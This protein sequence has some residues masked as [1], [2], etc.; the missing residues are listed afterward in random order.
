MKKAQKVTEVYNVLTLLQ[1]K[2]HLAGLT[3]RLILF[4]ASSSL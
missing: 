2:Q 3:S 4:Q 1:P